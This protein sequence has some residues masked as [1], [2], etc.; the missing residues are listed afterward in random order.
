MHRL[1]RASNYASL[2][3]S[4]KLCIACSERQT[5]HR[6]SRA[7]NYAS[8]IQSVKLCIACPE[9]QME[10]GHVS[11]D[12]ELPDVKVAKCYS[13]Y[14][15]ILCVQLTCLSSHSGGDSGLVLHVKR[16]TTLLCTVDV[17][18]YLTQRATVN[19]FL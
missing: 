15:C 18:H 7:S 17:S 12:G 6:L 9:R 1:F 11:G 14:T 19:Y 2:V 5:M 3:Q 4:V 13:L 8:V 10:P 16:K